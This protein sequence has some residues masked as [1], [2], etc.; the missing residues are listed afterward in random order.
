MVIQEEIPAM[1]TDKHS[2]PSLRGYEIKPLVLGCFLQVDCSWRMDD[3]DHFEYAQG[4]RKVSGNVS[5][6]P[7]FDITFIVLFV[8]S[9][10]YL[11]ENNSK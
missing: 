3:I 9:L 4:T 7:N 1:L 10:V 6:N 5:T 2:S 8:G 11:R